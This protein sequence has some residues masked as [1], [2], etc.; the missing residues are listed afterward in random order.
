MTHGRAR[1]GGYRAFAATLPVPGL[2]L[3][4]ATRRLLLSPGSAIPLALERATAGFQFC[5]KRYHFIACEIEALAH[6][7]QFVGQVIGRLAASVGRGVT[8]SLGPEIP[9][10]RCAFVEAVLQQ[11]LLG[12]S[13]H[14]ETSRDGKPLRL[15]RFTE[16]QCF[17]SAA[18]RP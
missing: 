13:G 2:I 9:Q 18:M 16:R 1:S 10:P 6:P 5:R 14:S 17:R 3:A 12:R 8:A 7:G 11:F 4:G 15:A